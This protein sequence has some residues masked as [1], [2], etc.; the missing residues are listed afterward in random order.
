MLRCF[1]CQLFKDLFYIN[2]FVCSDV[3]AKN[4]KDFLKHFSLCVMFLVKTVKPGWPRTVPCNSK[5]VGK[6]Q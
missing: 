2:S 6:D 5:C 3:F 4:L 1:I